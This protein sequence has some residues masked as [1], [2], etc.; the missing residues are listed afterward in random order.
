MEAIS[1]IQL[2]RSVPPEMP[3]RSLSKYLVVAMGRHTPRKIHMLFS[4]AH[5]VGPQSTLWATCNAFLVPHGGH[6]ADPTIPLRPPRN[7]CV[8]A[9]YLVVGG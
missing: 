4:Q 9:K 7:A 8:R 6:L 2:F 5:D 1:P 3:A